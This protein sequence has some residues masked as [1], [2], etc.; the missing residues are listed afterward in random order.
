MSGHDQQLGDHSPQFCFRCLDWDI[1]GLR[2]MSVTF[3][4]F[5]LLAADIANIV[6]SMSFMASQV[7]PRY[8]P[9]KLLPHL[10]LN[11]RTNL[12]NM[13]AMCVSIVDLT[14]KSGPQENERRES[15]ASGT[16]VRL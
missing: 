14:A 5:C 8:D 16:Q 3:S 2:P 1:Y 10:R 9:P 6:F 11:A 12:R 13:D 7:I 4:Y 15:T